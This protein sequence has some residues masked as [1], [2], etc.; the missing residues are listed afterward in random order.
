MGKTRETKKAV[1]RYV[2]IVFLVVFLISTAL[3]LLKLWE[4]KQGKYTEL[5][6]DDS[7]VEFEGKEYILRDGVE[8]LLVMGLDKYE[9]TLSADSYNN[10]QQADLLVLFV[11]DDETKKCTAIH[12]N[13]DCM[14]EMNVLGVAGQK[15]D[16]VTKQIALAHTYGNGKEISC[17]NT[18]DA[19]SKLLYGMKVKNYISLTMDSVEIFN[20]LVGGVELEV[21][22]DFTGIDDTLIKG[23]TVTLKGAQALRY[24][25]TRYGLE[26]SSNSTRMERQKQYMSALYDKTMMSLNDDPEFIVDAS[27]EMSE[28]IVSNRSIT[29]LQDIAE[30]FASYEL[31]EISAIK[32][33]SVVGEEYMEFYPDEKELEKTVIELFYKTVE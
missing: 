14:I 11:F 30:K 19:V 12:I 16:T 5:A 1:F 26:D 27:L 6:E 2:A 28:Y 25:R 4:N 21:L 18:A 24:V 33:E 22:D 9:G 29:Q 20:D 23:E 10:N 17:R 3:F 15:I 31:E 13:R 32:G 7:I 8:T